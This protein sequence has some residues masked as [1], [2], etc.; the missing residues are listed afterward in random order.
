MKNTDLNKFNN[1]L[2]IDF[3]APFIGA[4]IILLGITS[5]GIIGIYLKLSPISRESEV[6]WLCKKWEATTPTKNDKWAK[7]KAYKKL[8]DF[9]NTFEAYRFCS[10]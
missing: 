1:K 10:D 8:K 2:Y 7:A 5:L 4:L 9:T 6:K 3:N